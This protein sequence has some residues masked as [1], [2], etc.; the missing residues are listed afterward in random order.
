MARFYT[1]FC[2]Y[3]KES[4]TWVH[5][6]L[7]PLKLDNCTKCGKDIWAQHR[8]QQEQETK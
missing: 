4:T 5:H 7:D 3:C 1:E 6:D 8:E 2:L